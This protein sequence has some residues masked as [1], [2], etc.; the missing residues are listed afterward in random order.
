MGMDGWMSAGCGVEW[1][2]GVGEKW[3]KMDWE[4]VRKEIGR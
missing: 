2:G 3:E 1:S 4:I